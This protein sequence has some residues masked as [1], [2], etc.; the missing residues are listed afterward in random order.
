MSH[1]QRREETP[2]MSNFRIEEIVHSCEAKISATS[3]IK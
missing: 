3:G 2:E 1:K